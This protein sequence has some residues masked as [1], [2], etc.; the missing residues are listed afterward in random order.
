MTRYP[1]PRRRITVLANSPHFSPRLNTDA[2]S[3]VVLSTSRAVRD[4]SAPGSA[5]DDECTL[6]TVC[7]GGVHPCPCGVLI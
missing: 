7:H 3:Y 5:C 2:Q 1:G 6:R 4:H